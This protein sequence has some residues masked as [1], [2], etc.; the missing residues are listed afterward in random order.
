MIISKLWHA[1]LPSAD[2]GNYTNLISHDNLLKE[3]I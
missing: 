1:D 3:L 2:L